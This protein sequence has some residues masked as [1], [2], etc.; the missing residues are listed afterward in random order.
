MEIWT[1]RWHK[2][3][4]RKLE[5]QQGQM[6]LPAL[7]GSIPILKRMRNENVGPSV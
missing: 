3:F 7:D 5:T 2:A 4:K 6:T 1:Q